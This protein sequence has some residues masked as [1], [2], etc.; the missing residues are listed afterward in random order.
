MAAKAKAGQRPKGPQVKLGDLSPGVEQ[1]GWKELLA[2]KDD[3][4]QVA[5]LVPPPLFQSVLKNDKLR[6]DNVSY[7]TT[8]A[9]WLSVHGELP[10][11]KGPAKTL[12]IRLH[13]AGKGTWLE[14]MLVLGGAGAEAAA[15]RVDTSQVWLGVANRRGL[16][17]RVAGAAREKFTAV[18]ESNMFEVVQ[19]GGSVF[20]T[21]GWSEDDT[22]EEIL[23]QLRGTGWRAWRV[24][25]R[26]TRRVAGSPC[27]W[28]WVLAQAAPATCMLNVESGLTIIV[29]HVDGPSDT[30]PAAVQDSLFEEDMPKQ[31]ALPPPP[32]A[33]AGRA[34]PGLQ[35]QVATRNA[36][37]SSGADLQTAARLDRLE[38]DLAVMR[39][40]LQAS[41]AQNS[42][43]FAAIMSALSDLTADK[44]RKAAPA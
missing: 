40:D 24:V 2:L 17:I 31:L 13:M 12:P 6:R 35:Q 8:A 28:A 41:A 30:M 18:L 38:N 33:K 22:D 34:P 10:D 15:Q 4:R 39:G 21:Q 7:Y 20:V 36:G 43:Q 3:T 25:R 16:G 29:C 5:I 42:Q 26:M 32:P 19:G 44:R 9:A 1:I 11:P 37:Q 23:E 14:V 27:H